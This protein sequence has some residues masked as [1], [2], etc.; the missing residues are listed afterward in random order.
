M[1]A[2]ATS[3]VPTTTVAVTRAVDVASNTSIG[4]WYNAAAGTMVVAFDLN[5]AAA[6]SGIVS[7]GTAASYGLLAFKSGG[8]TVQEYFDN[9]GTTVGNMVNGAITKMAVAYDGGISNAA[10]LNGAAP[11]SSAVQA[12]ITTPNKLF[13]GI[14]YTGASQMTGHIRSFTYYS[15][16][17]SNAQLQSFTT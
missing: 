10:A 4:S 7:C 9:N 6:T 3:Y 5:T 17:L 12:A 8:V 2:F 14:V 13:L 16:R 1:S 15:Q 11:V